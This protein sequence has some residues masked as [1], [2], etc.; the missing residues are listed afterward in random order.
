AIWKI[1]SEIS[2]YAILSHTWIHSIPG[3][4]TYDDWMK[5]ASTLDLSTHPGYQKIVNFCGVALEK[6]GLT[7]GWIDTVCIDKSSS[8]ELDESIRSM[9]KWYE[10]SAVCIAYLAHTSSAQWMSMMDPWF[11]RGWTLQ[12]FIAP[13]C[14]KFHGHKWNQLFKSDKLNDKADL[15]VQEKIRQIMKT[16]M[17]ELNNPSSVSIW[18]KMQWA[19]R[20]HVTRE[21]DIAYSLMGIFK[22]NMS[23]AYGEG[24]Q[25][26][27]VRLIKEILNSSGTDVIE[28]L[29]W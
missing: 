5:E 10:N 22:V 15:E 4:F 27:F 14:L 3:E 6:Y 23:I 7:L 19:A 24:A 16:D 1:V 11:S 9:Y 26:A 21:E 18:R 13:R 8:S 2:R 12:E 20:R 28:V 25:S 17:H 29:N